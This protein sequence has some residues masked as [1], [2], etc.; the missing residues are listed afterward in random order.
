MPP[1]PSPADFTAD[2]AALEHRQ[3]LLHRALAEVQA[4]DAHAIGEHGLALYHRLAVLNG[5]H[6]IEAVLVHAAGGEISSGFLPIDPTDLVGI[7]HR[8]KLTTSLLLSNLA[9][10]E[11]SKP[12][13]AQSPITWPGAKVITYNPADFQDLPL[14]QEVPAAAPEPETVEPEP[15]AV[16]PAAVEPEPPADEPPTAEEVAAIKDDLD[17]IFNRRPTAVKE[18]TA[19]FRSTFEIGPKTPVA[20]AITTRERFTWLRA[21]VDQVMEAINAFDQASQEVLA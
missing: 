18:M 20:K 13:Q 7:C 11:V 5:Q 10:P 8:Q 21:H 2:L 15:V 6:S 9:V 4:T 3:S 16:E 17:R 19:E 12:Q 1:E 14:Q